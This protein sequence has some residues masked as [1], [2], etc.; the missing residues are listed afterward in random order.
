MVTLA[1]DADD[2]VEDDAGVTVLVGVETPLRVAAT[3]K[4]ALPIAS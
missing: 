1:V 3:L 2:E 4:G